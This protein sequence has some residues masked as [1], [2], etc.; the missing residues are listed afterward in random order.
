M[1]PTLGV[2]HGHN[3]RYRFAEKVTPPGIQEMALGSSERRPI[4]LGSRVEKD[5]G[6][7]ARLDWA[8]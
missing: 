8:E 7:P 1:V 5:Y 6:C 4:F 2:Q 3:F